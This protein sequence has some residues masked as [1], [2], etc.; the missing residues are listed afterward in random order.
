MSGNSR[1]PEPT[2]LVYVPEPSWTPVFVAFGLAGVVVGIFAGWAWLVAGA[3][4]GLLALR[5]WIK[6]VADDLRRL[7]RRQEPTTA[8]L[9]ATPMRAARRR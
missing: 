1:A 7:P 5:S 4:L 2:E 9:P 3:F 6:R 8:T